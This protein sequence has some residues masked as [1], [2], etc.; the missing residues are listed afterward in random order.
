MRPALRQGAIALSDVIEGA[1]VLP[2]ACTHI[3]PLWPSRTTTPL[4]C[5]KER[6]LIGEPA[7]SLL[8]PTAD[9]GRRNVAA[10]LEIEPPF[11]VDVQSFQRS[12]SVCWCLGLRRSALCASHQFNRARPRRQPPQHQPGPDEP[13]EEGQGGRFFVERMHTQMP[14]VGARLLGHP[15]MLHWDNGGFHHS[16]PRTLIVQ[17]HLCLCLVMRG[18][19][20][21]SP[22]PGGL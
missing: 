5:G 10:Q 4:R 17:Q 14:R 1:Q 2:M 20:P 13:S 15:R 6:T 16:F 8:G 9:M 7:K 12:R 22:A 21:R 19:R 11:W 3:G 18:A